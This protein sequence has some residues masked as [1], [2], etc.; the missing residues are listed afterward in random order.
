M[1]LN[2]VTLSVTDIPRAVAFY[3]LLGF[4]QIVDAPHYARFE[5]RPGTCQRQWDT[6]R[7]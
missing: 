5:C 2:Q 3:K 6:L 1:E 4:K 7:D